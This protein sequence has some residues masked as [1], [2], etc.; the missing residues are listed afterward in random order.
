MDA[1]GATIGL[2]VS[3]ETDAAQIYAIISSYR[4]E[5]TSPTSLT[6][7]EYSRI[8]TPEPMSDPI[9]ESEIPDTPETI[10]NSTNF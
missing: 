1:S 3:E 4:S 9:E 5:L 6:D 7:L 8:T 10:E 2:E